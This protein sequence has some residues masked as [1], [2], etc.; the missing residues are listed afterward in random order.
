MPQTVPLAP[1]QG[2]TVSSSATGKFP[3]AAIVCLAIIGGVAFLVIVYKIYRF[4]HAR[5]QR[6]KLSEESS[7]STG[8]YPSQSPAMMGQRIT[9]GGVSLPP[10]SPK[11]FDS[12]SSKADLLYPTRNNK[13]KGRSIDSFNS[14]S[15]LAS[16]KVLIGDQDGSMATSPNMPVSIIE[17]VHNGRSRSP[18]S[19]NGRPL[20]SI[21]GD[22]SMSTDKLRLQGSRASL[23][24]PTGSGSSSKD[25]LAVRRSVV[26]N[27][28][29]RTQNLSHSHRSSTVS[30]ASSHPLAFP[31][32]PP[33]RTVRM[34]G[35][36]HAR[37][38]RI[39]IIPPAPLGT[40]LGSVV[41]KE[42]ATLAFSSLSGIGNDDSSSAGDSVWFGGVIPTDTTSD[43]A[44]QSGEDP[45]LSGRSGFTSPTS[46][47]ENPYLSGYGRATSDHSMSPPSSLG[48]V[49]HNI[50][51]SSLAFSSSSSADYLS[52]QSN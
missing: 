39:E 20:S 13:L 50:S 11:T 36:P 31:Y 8:T 38:S 46:V 47:S 26:Q 15:A 42:K 45:A 19:S 44:V 27:T 24:H 37:H 22:S 48:D 35:P 17:P 52:P 6:N 41:A 23:M 4:S 5:S 43:E 25:S 12:L 51:P 21:R 34:A 2:S 30:Q 40:P 49:Q 1:T 3:L 16:R 28:L 9:V 7:I 14:F 33:M 29:S 10:Y 32:M 18:Q